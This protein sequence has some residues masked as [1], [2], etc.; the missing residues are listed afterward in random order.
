[1]ISE[2]LKK[3]QLYHFVY[4]YKYSLS[5]IFYGSNDDKSIKIFWNI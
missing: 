2:K 3:G 4:A 1:M 5:E